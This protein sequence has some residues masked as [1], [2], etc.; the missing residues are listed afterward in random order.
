MAI[1]EVVRTQQFGSGQLEAHHLAL[2]ELI[3]AVVGVHGL[4][5]MVSRPVREWGA[6]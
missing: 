1:D 2:D 6:L 4:P 5:I 3:E